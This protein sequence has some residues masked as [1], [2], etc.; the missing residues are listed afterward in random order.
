MA[1]G[2]AEQ[3]RST[4]GWGAGR[5]RMV[6]WEEKWLGGESLGP[7]GGLV[8]CAGASTPVGAP[9]STERGD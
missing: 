7:P 6:N 8:A 1:L 9:S 5:G 3:L 4:G 2:A